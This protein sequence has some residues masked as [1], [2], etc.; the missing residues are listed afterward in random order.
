MSNPELQL[1]RI[2]FTLPYSIYEQT[3]LI[4]EHSGEALMEVIRRAVIA[5]RN[6][7]VMRDNPTEEQKSFVPLA[8]ALL[9]M[10]RLSAQEDMQHA[11]ATQQ[12]IDVVVPIVPRLLSEFDKACAREDFT[13]PSEYI[14]AALV[15]YHEGDE[16]ATH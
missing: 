2:Q 4:A 9:A 6:M 15:F 3:R 14:N 7:E 13:S 5:R 12:V 11:M 16:P 10:N 1:P 8:E